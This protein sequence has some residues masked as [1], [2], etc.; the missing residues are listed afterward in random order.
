[1]SER[2]N[3]LRRVILAGVVAA[4]AAA[5]A[6]T[7]FTNTALAA[8]SCPA[9]DSTYVVAHEDDSIFF[10]N[11]DLQRDISSG[12]C[13][14]T[15]YLTAGDAGSGFSYWG[16]REDGVKAAYAQMAGLAN[17]WTQSDA[18]I[19]GHPIPVFSLQGRPTISLLFLRLPDGNLDGSG[20]SNYQRQSL[21]KLW[22]GSISSISAVNGSS[23]YTL[24]GL[25]NTLT[26]LMTM[27]G[28]DEVATQDFV[29]SFNDGDHSDHHAAAYLTK[30]AGQAYVTPHTLVGYQ[31]YGI[32]ARPVNLSQADSSAKQATYFTYAPYDVLVCQ[33][34]AQ[35]Q[36]GSGDYAKWWQRQ[37]VVG[38]I[39][40]PGSASQPTVALTP[41]ET[42]GAPGD[43]VQASA[44]L[45][46]V[47]PGAAGTVTYAV[48][49][50]AAC[51]TSFASAG[52]KTVTTGV[53]PDSN[54]VQFNAAGTYYWQAV[55]SGDA[56]NAGATS[57][58]QSGRL[59]IGQQSPTLSVSLSE[60]SG[61]TGDTV[62][63]SATLSGAGTGAGGTVTY[64]AYSDSACTTSF[65]GAGTKTVTNGVV[66]DSNGIQFNTAGSYYWQAAYS[67]DAGNS[68][69]N[70]SC[71][72]GQLQIAVP[73]ANVAS[74]AT[75][76][77]SSENPADGQLAVNAVDGV[78]DGYPGDYTREWATNGEGAGAWIN[79]A[80]SSPKTLT[81]I[82]LYDRPNLNDQIT[83]GTLSFS[84][85]STLP[86]GTLPNDGAALTL[87][88]AAKTVISLRLTVTS[89]SATTL[90]VGL[91]EIQA[92]V[93]T[94]PAI[95]TTLSETA[96]APGDAVHASASLS[97]VT[98]GA[99]G[100]VTYS[101]YSDS[102]CVNSFAGA[103]TKTVTS[104]VVPDSNTIQFNT[105]GTYYWQTAYSGD[106]ENA[107]AVSPCQSG[108]LVIGQQSPTASINLSETSGTTGDTVHA[109]A[110]LS[111][112]GTGAGGMVTYT[113]YS[114][115]ACT[116]VFAGAGT[117]TV[118]SG[119]V[120]DSTAIQFDTA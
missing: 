51:T 49:S 104:G 109:S 83:G 34:V 116:T 119:A 40:Q 37:Y 100:T 46:G 43:T 1:M 59:V 97:G 68:S 62:H 76:T 13:V 48:Y 28:P 15:I 117:K 23:S 41:S 91:A 108:R 27:Y 65:A 21:Q 115:S 95:A 17:T 93:P 105:A 79:L 99:G 29:G 4:A 31:D 107:G 33:T 38:V 9:G 25:S 106:A 112:A 110:T 35:C 42:T 78:I 92:M 12:R 44:S 113:V 70:S 75:V 84:D 114:D 72:S 74:L 57:L 5:N 3:W 63:A 69:A 16:A 32:S 53:V 87:N 30:S 18:G 118:T 71:Q 102:A 20:F 2:R 11:P 54:G 60:T 67:G 39:Q 111:G 64:T 47:L 98:T 88:F 58:C 26:Q 52:T 82:S 85:G 24:S 86:V 81:S 80:W 101:V 50:D 36:Q 61:T 19:S 7:S 8:A 89:V 120:P 94:A 77:A 45:S 90:N 56:Q 10:Q 103:G 55:Y 14:Q 73:S 6:L 22:Q 96:G 66:P